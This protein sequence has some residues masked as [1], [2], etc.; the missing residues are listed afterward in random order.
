M[1]E[2]V[3]M[4]VI[5]I[6]THVLILEN[7]KKVK[8]EGAFNPPLTNPTTISSIEIKFRTLLL[9]HSFRNIHH[10]F[11][12]IIFLHCVSTFH[13]WGEYLLSWTLVLLPT[14]HLFRSDEPKWICPT[15]IALEM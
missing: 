7:A 6:V 8:V 2:D 5:H 15:I 10:T 4:V 1:N 11:R 9:I 3:V 12:S 13:S 14:Q